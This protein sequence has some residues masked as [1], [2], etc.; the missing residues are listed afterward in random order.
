MYHVY[1]AY[2]I[3]CF[4]DVRLMLLED[5]TWTKVHKRSFLLHLKRTD[6]LAF[7]SEFKTMNF[8]EGYVHGNY[9]LQVSL[10]YLVYITGINCIHA[11]F[12]ITFPI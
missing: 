11:V 1:Y 5:K 12:F 4:R 3:C 9:T 8:I 2:Y 7:V 6:L 10:G